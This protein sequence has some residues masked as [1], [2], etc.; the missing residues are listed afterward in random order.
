MNNTALYIVVSY[1]SPL[2]IKGPFEHVSQS[3]N[4]SIVVPNLNELKRFQI[5][6]S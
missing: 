4:E 6:I 3:L 5:G 1:P 2:T